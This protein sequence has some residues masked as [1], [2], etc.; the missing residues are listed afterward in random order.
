VTRLN[1]FATSSNHVFP[2]QEIFVISVAINSAS[3][4]L[5]GFCV[6]KFSTLL[7]KTFKKIFGSIPFSIDSIITF[8][9]FSSC[10]H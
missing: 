9:Y 5:R 8:L 2:Y 10:N 3:T 7:D 1:T 6:S 4:G